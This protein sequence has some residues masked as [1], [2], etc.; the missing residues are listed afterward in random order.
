M[1]PTLID[2]GFAPVLVV[3]RCAM[4]DRTPRQ[5]IRRFDVF[6]EY[7]RAKNE[8]SGMPEDRA[9][10]DAIW[11]AKVV[12]GRRGGR[13]KD[14]EHHDGGAHERRVE[15]EEDGFRS[16]GGVPQTD[17]TFDK[18]IVERMGPDF[19]GEVFRP[20]IER[21]F[22]EGKKYEEIR[23]TIRKGWK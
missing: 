17:R 4:S 12:A 8:A 6:A 22:R 18:E 7:N 3:S 9:K 23:D 1:L 10:G 13:V 11:L 20:A 19:Y 21:A 5:P 2:V 16:A 14:A 15:V